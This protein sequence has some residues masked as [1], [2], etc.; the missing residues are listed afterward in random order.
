MWE[1]KNIGA[2]KDSGEYFFQDAPKNLGI[3]G[4][5]K[6]TGKII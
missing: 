5:C 6:L 3:F 4:I 2:Q 1:S